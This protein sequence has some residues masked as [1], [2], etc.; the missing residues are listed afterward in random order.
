MFVN[1]YPRLLLLSFVLISKELL[2]FN[3]EILVLLSFVLFSG[4]FVINLN[5][6]IVL[7][8]KTRIKKMKESYNFLKQLQSNSLLFCKKHTEKQTKF[9]F[10]LIKSISIVNNEILLITNTFQLI[11][12]N[13]IISTG[14]ICLSSSI[15]LIDSIK[16]HIDLLKDLY[17]LY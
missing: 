14:V 16:C 2:I 8:L 10:F 4:L 1:K 12:N 5:Q 11:F 7:D 9:M 6:L 15:V 17:K 3:E 13:K